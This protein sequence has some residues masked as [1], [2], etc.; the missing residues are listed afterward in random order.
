VFTFQ[1]VYDP[2]AGSSIVS[3]LMVNDKPLMV[4]APAARTIVLTFPEVFG[5]GIRMLDNLTMVPKHKLE[6]DLKA[7]KFAQSW[8]AST[9]VADLL[10]L[11]PFVLTKYEPGQ[12]L[13][14]DRNPKYWKKDAD[15]V[16]LPYLDQMV[17]EIVPDQNAELIRIQSAQIDLLQQEVRAED[18][19]TLRPLV[20]DGKLQLLDLGVGV[21]PD[22]LIFNLKDKHWAKDPRAAWITRKEFRQAISHAVDREAFANTIFLGEAVPIWG[23]ITPGNKQWFSPNVKRYPF[24]IEK[25]K[26]ILASIGLKNR[27]A[28]E[29][30]E[31]D[32]G[33]E[34]QFTVITYRGNTS[35]ERASALLA[36]DLK[37]VGIKVDVALLES[38]AL[39]D[40]LGNTGDFDAIYFY[41]TPTDLNPVMS[42]DLWLSTGTSHFWNM[43]Q[44]AP[45]SDWER[46]IDDLMKK[47][48]VTIDDAEAKRLFDQVQD[49]FADNLPA[50]YF[51]QKRVYMGASTR[52]TNLTPAILRPQLLWSPDTISIKH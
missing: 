26:E 11:G 49:I 7:G 42:L 23:P 21:D 50:L 46:Q 20:R 27:D 1:A 39:L 22:M 6:G 12:R 44:T 8:G 34:A 17:L 40:R 32:K 30:L 25:S 48:S 41:V 5:P 13:V 36:Q 51:V 2:K 43:N 24:S 47:L 14:F 38:N 16:Q 35:L 3:S 9:P 37:A 4:T 31:D 33:N 18:I 19:A 52:V 10:A 28:D 29:W 15:G 45:S